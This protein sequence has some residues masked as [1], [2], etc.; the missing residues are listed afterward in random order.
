MKLQAVEDPEAL[1]HV[2]SR[3]VRR[4]V[5]R[6]PMHSGRVQQPIKFE[7]GPDFMRKIQS[8]GGMNS[9][10]N[11]PARKRTSTSPAKQLNRL[12]WRNR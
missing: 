5:A 3:L 6:R 11:L 7:L 12:R 2:Q 9:R 10:K 4:Q 8:K 1:A